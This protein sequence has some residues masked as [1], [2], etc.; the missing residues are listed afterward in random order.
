MYVIEVA[1]S[2]LHEA[3][4]NKNEF[5]NAFILFYESLFTYLV[6]GQVALEGSNVF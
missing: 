6:P 1:L 2:I 3:T 4:V 5:F